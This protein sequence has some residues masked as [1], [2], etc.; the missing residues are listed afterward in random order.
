MAPRPQPSHYASLDDD[1]SEGFVWLQRPELP[2]RCVVRIENPDGRHA[3][4]CEALQIEANFLT[5]YNQTPRYHILVPTSAIVMSSWYR[6]KLGR[7]GTQEEY[8]L[9][10]TRSDAWWGK[11]RARMQHPQIVVRVAAWLGVVSVALGAL[12]VTLGV[13]SLYLGAGASCGE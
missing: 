13:V 7:L 1:I 10:I 4:Y 3:V 2:A 12:S 8:Q 6:E 5:K 11:L 9:Q